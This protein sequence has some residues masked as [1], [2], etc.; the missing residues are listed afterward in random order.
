MHVIPDSSLIR[1]L[2]EQ[3]CAKRSEHSTKASKGRLKIA[4]TG[5]WNCAPKRPLDI[6][7]RS[8]LKAR[9]LEGDGPDFDNAEDCII[10]DTGTTAEKTPVAVD[11][12]RS[13]DGLEGTNRM[14]EAKIERLEL[15]PALDAL[16]AT[17][18]RERNRTHRLHGVSC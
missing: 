17:W 5:L 9:K 4:G 11:K 13:V 2:P 16:I 18:Q 10:V 12:V 7:R 14:Q 15:N 8:N 1:D 6:L 3:R